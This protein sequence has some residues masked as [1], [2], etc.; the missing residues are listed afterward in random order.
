[1]RA[2]AV[3]QP[4]HCNPA[5]ASATCHHHPRACP[6]LPARRLGSGAGGVPTCSGNPLA[7]TNSELAFG[8]LLAQR[9]GADFQLLAWGGA[10]MVKHTNRWVR[11]V[12][13]PEGSVC[14]MR[15][16]AGLLCLASR[17]A[18]GGAAA[19]LPAGADGGTVLA[20]VLVL[21]CWAWGGTRA[22]TWLNVTSSR[23]FAASLLL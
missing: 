6:A 11:V 1:M 4:F 16:A 19:C 17:G 5:R 15:R 23:G 13:L 7:D 12:A 20:V 10:P 9:Y 2:A 18:R 21:A 22:L 8:P 14:A 3:R